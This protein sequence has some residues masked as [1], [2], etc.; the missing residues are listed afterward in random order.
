MGIGKF[1]QDL[2]K[3]QPPGALPGSYA[4]AARVPQPSV[5]PSHAASY[6]IVV[7]MTPA[8]LLRNDMAQRLKPFVEPEGYAYDDH[9]SSSVATDAQVVIMDATPKADALFHAKYDQIVRIKKSMRKLDDV[10]CMIGPRENFKKYPRGTY[11]KLRFFCLKGEEFDHR[12]PDLTLEGKETVQGPALYNYAD[13]GQVI[14]AVLQ[15]LV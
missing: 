13:I 3:G 5:G 1:L 10:L 6:R 9:P 2:F 12:D 11:P 4:G 15:K 7:L 14:S 8:T